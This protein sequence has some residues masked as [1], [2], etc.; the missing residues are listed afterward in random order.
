MENF[1]TV[2][3]LLELRVLNPRASTSGIFWEL[4]EMNPTDP[5]LGFL[6]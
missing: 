2:V 5:E 4:P 6:Q 1:E 3:S